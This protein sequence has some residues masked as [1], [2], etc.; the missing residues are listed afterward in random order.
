MS[1]Q[2]EEILKH[3]NAEQ[4]AIVTSD[5]TKML[6]LA[7]AGSGKTRTLIHR[8]A[9]L[10]S[11]G[12]DPRNILLLTF[13]NKA[14]NE[15][16]TRV[17]LLTGTDRV[18]F[19]GGTFHHIGQ[20]IIRKYAD[21]LGITANFGILDENDSNTLFYDCVR[22]VNP[23]FVKNKDNPKPSVMLD[24]LSYARN[25]CEEVT[26]ILR[27][28]YPLFEHLIGEIAAFYHEYKKRKVA[29]N[30]LDYDDL[31]EL[32][33]QLMTG[34]EDVLAE[35]R[36]RFKYI[37]VDEYQDTN[38]LQNNIINLIADGNNLLV[39]GDDAQCIYSW[40]GANFNNI[41]HFNDR[42]KDAAILKIETNYRSTPEI[43][44]FANAIPVTEK[45][46][47]VKNLRAVRRS[48]GR[49]PFIVAPFNSI[50]QAKFIAKR[51][52]GL[53][54]EGYNLA[55][56]AVLY[57][58]HFHSIDVQMELSKNGI[59][60]SI[61]SGIRFFEQAHIKDILSV[62]RFATNQSDSTAFSRM[63]CRLPRVGEKSAQK[64]FSYIHEYAYEHKQSIVEFI[65]SEDVLEKFPSDSRV[66]W[67]QMAATLQQMMRGIE[68]PVSKH[69]ED[70]FEFTKFQEENKKLGNFEQKTCGELIQIALDGEYE[71]FL[72]RTFTNWSSRCDD[73]YGLIDFSNRYTT[74]AEFLGQIALM[75][76]E[77][78]QAN[79]GKPE[80]C[81]RLTTI[82]QAKGL[83][84]GVVFVIGL[85]EN[86][87]PLKRAI[88]EESVNEECRLFYVAATRA[89][90]ELYLCSPTTS[91]TATNGY[92]IPLKPSRFIAN[93]P[94]EL[95][96]HLWLKKF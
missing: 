84:F 15:M 19:W 76:S 66:F 63:V 29:E 34:N 14:A 75:Q 79:C 5:A 45:K 11:N 40:R 23:A 62:L 83:E 32:W 59:P 4:R 41:L 26:G 6:V 1:I 82:H 96:E 54:S 85:V 67:Q 70:L 46:E 89:K 36:S 49:K 44:E 80:D 51:I 69:S 3:L 48:N 43:L 77:E 73:I 57:R 17:E 20:R 71:E 12:I 13:T 64:I 10:L 42:H 25:T 28:K 33:Y 88:E 52:I 74:I 95:T 55:E 9:W 8:V 50:Q 2:K 38:T 39:V 35:C 53:Q 72:R 68:Q 18:Y 24:I 81:V 65:T 93:I 60:Y 30:Q 91:N 61:T 16:L 86:Q 58:A 78:T 37:L 22:V 56:I 87:F 7:G 90:D 47:F 92:A 27:E 94:K 21:R 31:L